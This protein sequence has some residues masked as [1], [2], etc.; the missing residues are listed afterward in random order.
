[1]S[2][3][4]GALR[5][6]A[7]RRAGQQGRRQPEEPTA[8]DRGS[9]PQPSTLPSPPSSPPMIRVARRALRGWRRRNPATT[10]R[11]SS[12]ERRRCWGVTDSRPIWTRSAGRARMLRIQSASW[13]QAEKMTASRVSGSY[14]RT[15][16]TASRACR[17]CARRGSAA[18]MCGLGASPS[19]GDTAAAVSGRLPGAVAGEDRGTVSLAGRDAKR[20][21][22]PLPS[23]PNRDG[24]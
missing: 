14:C 20:R 12:W 2:A 7:V 9:S 8:V 15:M 23:P 1:M 6:P 22:L 3:G 13:P 17:S 19:R 10:A 5:R 18:G 11:L 24:P 4:R 21:G 16:A